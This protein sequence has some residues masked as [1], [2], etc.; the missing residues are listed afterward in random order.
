[1]Y[2]NW[3]FVREEGVM[4]VVDSSVNGYWNSIHDKMT[5]SESIYA[6]DMI[7]GNK[8][9]HKNHETQGVHKHYQLHH[10]RM[11]QWYKEFHR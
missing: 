9:P 1:M 8:S 7:N 10:T 3:F 2:D 6:H 5:H 11:S 4:F